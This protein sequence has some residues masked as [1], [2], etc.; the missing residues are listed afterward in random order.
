MGSFRGNRSPTIPVGKDKSRPEVETSGISWHS[1]LRPIMYFLIV[2]PAHELANTCF[3]FA[4]DVRLADVSH[5]LKEVKS[6]WDRRDLPINFDKSWLLTAKVGLVGDR[7]MRC[8]LES[9][10]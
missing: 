1:V 9:R 5:N 6:W 4:V 3:L 7:Q 2:D 10:R 8:L